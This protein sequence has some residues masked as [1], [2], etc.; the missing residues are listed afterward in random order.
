MIKELT[1]ET[2]QHAIDNSTLPVLVVWRA[3]LCAPCRQIYPALEKLS[4]IFH[5][6]LDIYKIDID[7]NPKISK[8]LSVRGIPTLHLFKSGQVHAKKLG[9][10][11]LSALKEWLDST[12]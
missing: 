1:D 9:S 6:Q 11:P 5:Q 3:E 8:E 2:F 12:L 10:L 7:E 4:N